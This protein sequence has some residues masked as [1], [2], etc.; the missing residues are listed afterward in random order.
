MKWKNYPQNIKVRLIT[1][2]FNRAV[3]SAVMPFMALFFAQEMSKVWAGL[4]LIGTVCV[5]FFIS[6]IGGYISD[7]LPRKGLLVITSL[8]SGGM[9]VCMTL[10][11]LPK[12]NI[13]WMFAI[14]YT[15]YY[16]KQFR[17][18]CYACNHHRFYF[19]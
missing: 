4:F 3:S 1:S 12:S 17:E 5:S 8:L 16:Y 10:S 6:L 2:F 7:R 18:A 9:F 15:L 13:I 19:S 14:A 11:L